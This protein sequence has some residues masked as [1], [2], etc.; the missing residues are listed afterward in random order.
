MRKFIIFWFVY[1][2]LGFSFIFSLGILILSFGYLFVERE[3]GWE[4]GGVR[5]EK[6]RR[7]GLW[8][9]MVE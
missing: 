2:K 6:G 8:W 9:W 5:R 1:C 3:N 7:L 4:M